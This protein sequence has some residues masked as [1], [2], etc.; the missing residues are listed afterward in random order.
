MELYGK[1]LNIAMPIFVLL[2]FLERF[3]EWKKGKN[4]SRDL[5]SISSISSGMT[6]IIKDVLGISISIISYEW[7]VH[8]IAII[9]LPS[10]ALTY[11]ITFVVLDFKGYWTHRWEHKINIFWNRHVIHHSSEEFNLA[12]ALRQNIS[13]IVQYFTFLL[14]PA[15][16]LGVPVEVIAIVAPLHLFLQFWYHTR[17]IGKMGWLEYVLVTPSHH[18]VHHAINPEYVDKNYSQIF[19]IWDKWFGSFQEERSDVPC[20]Y[21][22][23]R[24][25]HTWNPVKINLQHLWLLVKDAY[26]TNSWKDKLRIW[27]MPTGWRPADVADAFPVESIKNPLAQVKYDTPASLGF[28]IW[29]WI[30]L[31]F[32]YFLLVYLFAFIAKIGIPNIYYYGLFVVGSIY[33]YTELMDGA[34]Y[35]WTL[36][37][38][39]SLVGLCLIYFSGD[40]FGSSLLVGP[41]FTTGIGFYL[42]ISPPMA[43]WFSVHRQKSEPVPVPHHQ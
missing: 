8:H 21:G 40:W 24:P 38:I 30:Q 22:I 37:L 19:I 42:L 17:L 4:Y 10:N 12:C 6:N 35:T 29:S 15:A 32:N 27:F 31:F 1:V 23:T 9:H 33:A 39:K 14:I 3:L 16:V 43:W 41:W 13:A 18:R 25:A 34:K 20:V 5:D 11:V 7:M 26:R 2:V 28:K 36:E